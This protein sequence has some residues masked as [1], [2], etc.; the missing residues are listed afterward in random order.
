MAR[1]TLADLQGAMQNASREVAR[2][3]TAGNQTMEIQWRRELSRIQNLYSAA[4][5]GQAIQDTQLTPGEWAKATIVQA[6][7]NIFGMGR[8][9][10]LGAVV[11]VALQFL[12]RMDR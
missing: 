3:R 9:L 2:Y 12:D 11:F 8:M 1:A 6:G 5:A 4:V 7:K 10:A